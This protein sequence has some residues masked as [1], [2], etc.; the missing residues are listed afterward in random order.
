MPCLNCLSV[1]SGGDRDGKTIIFA[2]NKRHAQ[3][4]VERFDNLFPSI[5]EDLPSGSFVMIVN[6]Y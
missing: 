5:K 3:F 2:Q 6:V 4:L 1:D